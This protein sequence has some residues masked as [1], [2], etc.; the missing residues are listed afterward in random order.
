[1]V[2]SA[3]RIL[4]RKIRALNSLGKDSSARAMWY[5]LKIGERS[6]LDIPKSVE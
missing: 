4:A 6:Q 3:L 5:V 2:S 1:M